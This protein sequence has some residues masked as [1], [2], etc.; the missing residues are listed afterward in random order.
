[1]VKFAVNIL[2]PEKMFHV[3]KII[4]LE[5]VYIAIRI[6]LMINLLPAPEWYHSWYEPTTELSDAY[7]CHH[8]VVPV[9]I[10]IWKWNLC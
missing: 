1:M 8:N 6:S 2:K 10:L 7:T 9:D 5:Y 4:L 3:L